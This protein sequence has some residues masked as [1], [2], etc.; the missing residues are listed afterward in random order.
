MR[1]IKKN[2]QRCLYFHLVLF[3]ITE[4]FVLQSSTIPLPEEQE[5]LQDQ[6]QGDRQG[7]D[8]SRPW[9]DY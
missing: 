9:I 8:M 3:K 7:Q 2:G 6:S 4:V 1:Q 5:M